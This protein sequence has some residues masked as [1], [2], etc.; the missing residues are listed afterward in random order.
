[1]K[2]ATLGKIFIAQIIVLVLGTI[3]VF[4]NGYPF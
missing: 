3:Y 1:M 4:F 2:E